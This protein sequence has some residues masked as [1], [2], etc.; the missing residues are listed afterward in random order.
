M[1]SILAMVLIGISLSLSMSACTGSMGVA[2]AGPPGFTEDQKH[3][4][5]SAALA[6]SESP[7]ESE[8]FKDVCR[9]IGIVDSH[10]NPND[11]Y[12]AFVKAHIEWAMRTENEPF[13]REINT[14]DKARDY[15]GKHLPR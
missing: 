2:T 15:L 3:R 7:L 14:K 1:K 6:A 12:M 8:T 5:Y 9:K 10:G 13:K 4:L 11:S